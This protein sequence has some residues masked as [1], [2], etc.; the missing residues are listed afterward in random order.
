MRRLLHVVTGL[1]FAV[2][3]AAAANANAQ[4][5]QGGLRGAVKD[6]QGVIPGATVT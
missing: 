5:F 3:L 4:T 2:S 1:V 6:A